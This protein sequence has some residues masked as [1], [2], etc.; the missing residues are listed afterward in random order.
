[1]GRI[2]VN[3]HRVVKGKYQIT[4]YETLK[5]LK[6]NILSDWNI[7]NPKQLKKWQKAEKRHLTIECVKKANKHRKMQC[8]IV[9]TMRNFQV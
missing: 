9:Y 1:M 7:E 2:G 8:S 4:L 6:Q 3:L 5:E